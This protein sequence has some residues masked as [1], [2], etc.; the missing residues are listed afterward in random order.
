MNLTVTKLI[1]VDQ[2]EYEV[3]ERKGL[4]H[5]DTLADGIAESISVEYSRYCLSNFGVILHHN[6]DKIAIIGGECEIRYGQGR[7][8]KP[9][10]VILNGRMSKCLGKK[11]IDI[12][13]IQ[14]G[15]TTKYLQKI[16]P[17]LRIEKE[18]KVIS[19][20]SS[21]SRNP[22]W[23]RPRSIKD[24]PELQ[25]P[26][27]NDTSIAV[28]FWPLSTMERIVLLCER[29]FYKDFETLTSRFKYVGRDIKVMGIRRKKKAELVLCVPFFAEEIPNRTV[30]FE[31]KNYI[32]TALLEYLNENFG[33][34]IEISLS[35]N[36]QDQKIRTKRDAL[37]RYLTVTGTALDYGEEGVTGRGNRC[38]GLI[39]GLRPSG[40]E[41]IYGKNPV[42]HVGKIYSYIANKIAKRIAVELECETNV[43]IVTRNGDPL[44]SPRHILI[45]LSTMREKKVIQKIIKECLE[46]PSISKKI[47]EGK[48]FLPITELGYEE[49]EI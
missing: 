34:K 38:R 28:G 48:I 14:I 43:V 47:V 37:G 12:E 16:L 6:V 20:V 42:Y 9:F 23:F 31:Y 7:L 49:K 45:Q 1:P 10:T 19:L 11:R 36:T 2:L 41:A 13:E 21:S 15:A 40:V 30:Y 32:Q 24:L 25:N 8:L 46:E 33:D 35:I 29:F 22:F 3:V 39:S 4:G 26:F 44:F 5:P 18:T 17:S 27:A